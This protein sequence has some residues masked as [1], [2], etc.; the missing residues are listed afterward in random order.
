MV[1][2]RLSLKIP[3]KHHCKAFCS[4]FLFSLR[5]QHVV[6]LLSLCSSHC[7]SVCI[8]NWFPMASPTL[9]HGNNQWT[10]SDATL[11]NGVVSKMEFWLNQ[12]SNPNG[13][14]VPCSPACSWHFQIFTSWPTW[15]SGHKG[16][17]WRFIDCIVC[18]LKVQQNCWT[19][20]ASLYI[21]WAKYFK[22]YIVH[23]MAA[24][25]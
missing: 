20:L 6:K 1:H 16:T 14:P 18:I 15:H 10:G 22:S 19:H 5:I 8:H 2:T 21:S 9:H 23:R 3:L 12:R 4:C 25:K 11:Y 17:L 13:V 24:V 7:V